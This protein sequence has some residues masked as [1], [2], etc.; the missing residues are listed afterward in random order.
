MN[1][2]RYKRCIFIIS[3]IISLV[4][5]IVSLISYVNE[6]SVFQIIIGLSLISISINILY[7]FSITD[8]KKTPLWINYIVSPLIVL[9]G[10]HII[11][12]NIFKFNS[13]II[14]LFISYLLTYIFYELVYNNKICKS[15]NK[16][17]LVIWFISLVIM[18]LS[19]ITYLLVVKYVSKSM[20]F[21]ISILLFSS[22]LIILIMYKS[23][24][25]KDKYTYF[26]IFMDI[27]CL[28]ISFLSTIMLI[29]Y[30]PYV[31]SNLKDINDFIQDDIL[32]VKR[33]LVEVIMINFIFYLYVLFIQISNNR[34][35]NDEKRNTVK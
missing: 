5:I 13:L 29:K 25:I 7:F 18:S 8:I 22:S 11:S 15:L 26:T 34:K 10:V 16:K 31:I 19:I 24:K 27:N 28:I 4:L 30:S 17:L 20:L 3:C 33:Y 35:E 23:L 14:E 9:I 2:K 1:S 32:R 6:I 21:Y 12:I